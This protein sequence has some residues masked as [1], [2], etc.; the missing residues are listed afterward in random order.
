MQR[1]ANYRIVGIE[2]DGKRVVLAKG[3]TR[4]IAEKIVKLMT[5]GS[6]FVELLIEDDNDDID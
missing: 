5:P 4:E 1:N 3:A 6:T 2:K